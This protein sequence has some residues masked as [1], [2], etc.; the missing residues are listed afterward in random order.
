MYVQCNHRKEKL[1]GSVDLIWCMISLPRLILIMIKD[2]CR[3]NLY[4]NVFPRPSKIKFEISS[5]MSKGKK[6]R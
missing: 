1:F 6:L 4:T 5:E 2:P 3:D